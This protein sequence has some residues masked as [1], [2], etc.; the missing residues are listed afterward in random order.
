MRFSLTIFFVFLGFTIFSQE[1]SKFPKRLLQLQFGYSRLSTGDMNGVYSLL[2]YGKYF[3][4]KIKWAVSFGCT[5]HDGKLEL[6]YTDPGGRNYDGSI[7]YTTAG[8]QT[9]GSIGYSIF[10]NYQHEIE[11]RIGVLL[12]YQSSSYFDEVIIL[13][14]PA[15]NLPFPVSV[16]NNLSP[17]RSINVGSSVQLSYKYSI[18]SN[19]TLGLAGGFQADTNGDI[20]SQISLALGRRF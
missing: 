17:Q 12:R 4:K 11:V 19:I 1:R 8:L 6:D 18:A 20:V 15:T 14:P 2:E 16:F 9:T 3:R 7:R 5:I 10:Y 13:Y